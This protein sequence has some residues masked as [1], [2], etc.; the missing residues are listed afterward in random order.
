MMT[1]R[2]RVI[3]SALLA[4][5]VLQSVS[6]CTTA[7]GPAPSPEHARS[8]PV[9][10]VNAA[11]TLIVPPVPVPTPPPPPPP[12]PEVVI[13]PPRIAL[14]LGGGAARGFAHVGVIKVLEAQGLAPNLVVGTSA[15]SVVAALY[16]SGLSG[17]DLQRRAMDLDEKAVSDWVLPNRGFL[18][19][20]SLQ[21]YIN[22]AVKG[23]TIEQMGKP[24]GIV[25]TDLQTGEQTVFRRGNTGMAV[26]ASSSVPGVFQPV[27]INGREY[28]DGGLTSPVPVQAARDM[29]ADI[30]IA[31]DISKNPQRAK[32]RDTI[33]VLMQTF[34]IMGRALA[35]QEMRSADVVVLPSTDELRTADFES[36]HLAVLEG[37]RAMQQAL[38]RLRQKIVEREERLRVLETHSP[39]R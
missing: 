5:A 35:A 18:K 26:R 33:D 16:A 6:G 2:L 21:N 19:G 25:A 38:P 1:T 12:P 13:P 10:P 28:V 22:D 15:G 3:L 4:A 8:T 34:L 36:R 29:G 24:L 27:M 32:V 30:V 11:E 20:E 14:V 37:E 9:A 17:F 7:R 31:V 23:R 39:P